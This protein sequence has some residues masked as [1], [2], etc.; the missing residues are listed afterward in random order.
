M[1]KQ[2]VDF[3]KLNKNINHML[4]AEDKRVNYQRRETMIDAQLRKFKEINQQD[5]QTFGL[6]EPLVDEKIMS[7]SLPAQ[8]HGDFIYDQ[9]NV[10]IGMALKNMWASGIFNECVNQ[11]KQIEAKTLFLH[12]AYLDQVE[13]EEAQ[14][15][16]KK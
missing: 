2:A 5:N 10:R 15:L 3:S 11:N 6:T 14:C 16:K 9:Q 1:K 12:L 8:K 4:N 13:I 7:C